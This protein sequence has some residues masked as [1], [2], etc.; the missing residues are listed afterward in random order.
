MCLKL[1]ATEAERATLA[2]GVQRLKA[3]AAADRDAA[4][5]AYVAQAKQ[6][7]DCRAHNQQWATVRELAG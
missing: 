5:A 4:A 1:H 3:A 2:E 6:L 7:A